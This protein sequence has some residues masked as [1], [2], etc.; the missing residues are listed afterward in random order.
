[1][2]FGFCL[3]DNESII[4][5]Y[6]VVQN[7]KFSLASIKQAIAWSANSNTTSAV[8]IDQHEENKRNKVIVKS[9]TLKMIIKV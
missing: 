5:Q 2:S 7:L 9:E 1:M 8:E 6:F 3:F 4:V